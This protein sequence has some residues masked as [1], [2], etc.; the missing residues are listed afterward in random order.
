MTS[1]GGAT[2]EPLAPPWLAGAATGVGSLPGTDPLTAAKLVFDEL[3]DL[4]HLVELPGRG[5]GADMLGRAAVIALDLPVDLQP[6]GWRLVPRPGLDY[7][8]ARGMVEH[9][10]DALEEA[11]AGYTGPLKVAVA[12]P[13]TLAAG[14]ELT[15]GHKALS[16]PGATR[17]L[18]ESL[19][20]GLAET[21]ATIARRV[22][23][24][25]LVVQLD[26]PSL[27]SVLAG[28]I[29]TPSG[30]SVLRAVEEGLAGERLGLVLAE[31]SRVGGVAGAG[32][33]CC[34]PDVPLELLR[35]AGARFVGLDATLLT[36][37]SDE[38]IGEAVEAGLRFMM[39]VVPAT[40]RP[41]AVPPSPSAGVAAD[42]RTGTG[43][44]PRAATAVTGSSGPGTSARGAAGRL[45]LL[46][47]EGERESADVDGAGRGGPELSDP[48]RT[49]D[50]VR[51]LWRRLGFRPEQLAEVVAVTP[52]CG[53]A[54]A[55]VPYARAAMRHC[56]A[57]ARVLVESPE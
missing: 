19:A 44:R 45:G 42:A 43:P 41:A 6:S 20:A 17:D 55:S 36:Q 30:F 11:A 56:R 38:A 54:G 28:R 33:H 12:G 22:P 51:S 27:P 8:R 18:A 40:D 46:G 21:L 7:R 34:A 9:D 15:R 24:A 10:L 48:S 29:R 37:R 47:D 4:P 39:G 26:E 16:D 35:R 49:V 13:W 2:D 50:P 14:V 25:R 23:G 3:P 52:T 57:A 1:G 53:L 31:A 32:V 5:P